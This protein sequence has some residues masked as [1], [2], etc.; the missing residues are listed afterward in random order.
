[1]R[2]SRSSREKITFRCSTARSWNASIARWRML[3]G[4]HPSRTRRQDFRQPALSL[5]TMKSSAR[6]SRRRLLGAA[7]AAGVHLSLNRSIA[8]AFQG[9]RTPEFFD[10]AVV[11]AGLAGLT[12]ARELAKAGIDRIVVLD[13]R[14]RVGGRTVNHDIGNGRVVEGGGQWVGPTQTAVLRLCK[15]LGVETFK[16]YLKG[17]LIIK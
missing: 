1:M 5:N 14:D 3:I 11:G 4:R 13:A 8:D 10:V 6:V 9:P 15:E 2:S 7:T 17:N 12:T 16:T